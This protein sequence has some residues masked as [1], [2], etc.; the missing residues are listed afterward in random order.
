VTELFPKCP[1]GAYASDY[2]RH[3]YVARMYMD[4]SLMVATFTKEAP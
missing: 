4:M 3:P 1:C 2:S